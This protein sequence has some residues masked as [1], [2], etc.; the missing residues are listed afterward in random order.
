MFSFIMSS[1]LASTTKISH[2][3]NMQPPSEHNFIVC[4]VN[5]SVKRGKR[6]LAI[7]K[8]NLKCLENVCQLIF[9]NIV[10]HLLTSEFDL[11]GSSFFICQSV[12]G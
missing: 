8:I 2:N 1:R 10:T 3:S 12:F 4:S 6:F 11:C 5:G 7:D 9:H